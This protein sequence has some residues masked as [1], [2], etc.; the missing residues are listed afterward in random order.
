MFNILCT[1]GFKPA[2][3]HDLFLDYGVESEP[4][5]ETHVTDKSKQ[6][7]LIF[8]SENDDDGQEKTLTQKRSMQKT[9][10]NIVQLLYNLSLTMWVERWLCSSNAKDIGILYLIFALFSGLVGTAFSVLIRLE[11]SAPGTQFLGD[12]QLYNSIVTAHAIVMIF[13]MV[14]PSMIGGFGKI[15][16]NNLSLNYNNSNNQIIIK[17]SLGPYLAG[18]IEADGSIA[19][20]SKNSKSKPYNPKILIVFAKGYAISRKIIYYN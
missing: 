1:L 7:K 5:P 17:S 18:L 9:K 20:H 15:T 19:V 13:F 3:H 14:M 6:C 12:N 10:G 16:N 4:E 8:N 2:I 11:L